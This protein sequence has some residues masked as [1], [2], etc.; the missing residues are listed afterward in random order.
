MIF[1]IIV[2]CCLFFYFSFNSVASSSK[3]TALDK[4]ITLNLSSRSY[5]NRDYFFELIKQALEDEGYL[6]TLND[7]GIASTQRQKKHLNQNKTS[8]IWRLKTPLR[9]KNFTRVNI[10]LTKGFIAQRVLL[11]RENNQHIFNPIKNIQDLQNNHLVAAFGESWFDIAVWQHNNLPYIEL[12]G[13]RQKIFT[14]L[15]SGKRHID[16][17]SRGINEILSETK[18][19][20]NLQIEQNLL[21]CYQNDSYIYVKK[22]NHQLAEVLEKALSKAEKS[23]L[24]DKLIKKHWGNLKQELQLDSRTKI[25]LDMPNLTE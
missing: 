14:M 7:L 1:K 16:Y 23:G 17:F 2:L 25:T 24:L 22:D 4:R 20:P 21:L 13:D 3:Q 9:D 8:L 15:A 11:I 6:V 12:L 10:G 18:Q 5:D 19:Y